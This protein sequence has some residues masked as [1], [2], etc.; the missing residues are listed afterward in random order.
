LF[1]YLFTGAM[2]SADG[3]P[4][5]AFNHRNGRTTFAKLASPWAVTG[6]RRLNRKQPRL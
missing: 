6:L 5:L 3:Q 4:L 1:E 2:N